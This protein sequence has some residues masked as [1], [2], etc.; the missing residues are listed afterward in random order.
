MP[1]TLASHTLA[2]TRRHGHLPRKTKCRQQRNVTALATSSAAN[3]INSV[4]HALSLFSLTGRADVDKANVDK[5][6][7]SQRE[8]YPLR[9]GKGLCNSGTHTQDTA[10][11]TSIKYI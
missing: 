11:E 6:Y 1:N 3:S 9:R 10:F 2:T 4:Q 7:Y 5:K 8:G